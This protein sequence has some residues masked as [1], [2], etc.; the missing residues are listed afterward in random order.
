M[1]FWI[2][3]ALEFFAIPS[4]RKFGETVTSKNHT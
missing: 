1:T 3:P 4:G 2:K